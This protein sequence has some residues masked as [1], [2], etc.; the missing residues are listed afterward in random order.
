MGASRSRVVRQLLFESSLIAMLA[1]T[2]GIAIALP[3]RG[4]SSRSGPTRC[5]ASTNSRSMRACSRSRSSWRSSTMLIFGQRPGDP[6]GAA[7]SARRPAR[8]RPQR[9]VGLGPPTHPRCADHR[10]GGALGGAADRR[11]TADAQLRA[12]A[13]GGSGLRRVG[14]MTARV[15]LPATA[16][17]N[18]RVAPGVLRSLPRPICAGAGHRSRRHFERPAA[19]GRFHRGRRALADAIQR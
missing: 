13:A 16:Y 17:P 19:L 10:R 3:P 5:R 2:V 9:H 11:R 8:R 14:L 1:A 7:G 4:C 12:I 6:G 15:N 18:A